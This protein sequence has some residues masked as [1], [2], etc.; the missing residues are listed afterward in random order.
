MATISTATI[1]QKASQSFWFRFLNKKMISDVA[2]ATASIKHF[3]DMHANEVMLC[4]KRIQDGDLHIKCPDTHPFVTKAEFDP[5][6]KIYSQLF[7]EVSENAAATPPEQAR[8]PDR[9][10]LQVPSE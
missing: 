3:V 7:G 5:S 1:S 4:M 9:E 2:V 10:H 8:I 6:Y